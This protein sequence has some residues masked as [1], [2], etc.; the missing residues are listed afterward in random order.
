M[1]DPDEGDVVVFPDEAWDSLREQLGLP[2]PGW[3]N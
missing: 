3:H 2:L 1:I